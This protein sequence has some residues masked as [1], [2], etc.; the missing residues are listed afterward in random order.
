MRAR[1][2]RRIAGVAG[3][4]SREVRVLTSGVE[5]AVGSRATGAEL[6]E[7]L[8][9]ERIRQVPDQHPFVVR[10]I[11]VTTPPGRDAFQ[12][13]HHLAVGRHHLDR[14][15]VRRAGDEVQHFWICWISDVHNGPTTVPQVAHVEIPAV[16]DLLD[17][18]FE[19]RTTIQVA[20][21]DNLHVLAE[22]TL[23]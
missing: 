4:A 1:W 15:G 10:G 13:G 19:A 11:R 3:H 17:V 18:E 20:V 9:L 22:S 6:T 12:C 23:G 2:G 8:R 14:P 5:V 7:T 16:L 21:A